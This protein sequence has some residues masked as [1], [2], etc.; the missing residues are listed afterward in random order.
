MVLVFS[1][2]GMETQYV[3]IP[4]FKVGEYHQELK[5]TMQRR[6]VALE[7]VVVTGIFTRKRKVLRDRLL[8][9]LQQS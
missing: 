5:I 1:F 4:K 7:D 3:A 2:I 6:K 8:L 9:I